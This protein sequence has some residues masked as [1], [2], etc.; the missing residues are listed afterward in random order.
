MIQI[1]FTYGNGLHRNSNSWVSIQWRLYI[2]Q[3]DSDKDFSMHENCWL[4]PFA[5]VREM[6]KCN[7]YIPTPIAYR[8]L[9]TCHT[10]SQLLS[11]FIKSKT[12]KCCDVYNV[13]MDFDVL[14][15][16]TF[17]GRGLLT[18]WHSSPIMFLTQCCYNHWKPPHCLLLPF[19][20][21]HFNGAYCTKT[22][23]IL[24]E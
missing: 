4:K 24:L 21:N 16:L 7:K 8:V 19:T 6:A 5:A 23:I 12:E 2:C 15:H 22:F 13:W 17:E 14:S 18:Y 3:K 11:H 9:Q 1:S 10:W 20:G